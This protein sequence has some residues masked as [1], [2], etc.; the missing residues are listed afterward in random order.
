LLSFFKRST[1]A[2]TLSLGATQVE[3]F[4]FEKQQST[5]LSPVKRSTS[6]ATLSLRVTQVEGFSHGKRQTALGKRYK[7]N[8][9]NDEEAIRIM[10]TVLQLLKK[11]ISVEHAS[12]RRQI[13]SN[14]SALRPQ[15]IAPRVPHFNSIARSGKTAV[16]S[17]LCFAPSQEKATLCCGI[18]VCDRARD[19]V[20]P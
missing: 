5:L 12:A 17:C 1:P 9:K 3:G 18:T 8:Q 13:A 11:A 4:S 20:D 16:S 2:A 6:T 7:S 15:L 14:V 19:G 10:M